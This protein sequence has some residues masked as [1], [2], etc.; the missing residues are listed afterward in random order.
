MDPDP[1]FAS[2]KT[3]QSTVTSKQPDS[4]FSSLKSSFKSIDDFGQS[5]KMRLD[6]SSIEK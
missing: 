3:F 1:P 2:S 6:G 5:F 4:V